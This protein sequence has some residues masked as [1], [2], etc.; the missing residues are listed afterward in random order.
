MY[1]LATYSRD[2]LNSQNGKRN[3]IHY[4]VLA[5]ESAHKKALAILESRNENQGCT[6]K[7]TSFKKS[8]LPFDSGPP[9]ALYL[10][11]IS[12]FNR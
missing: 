7:I 12:L 9:K 1:Y 3:R 10:K 6:I 8:P 4:N 2:G 11:I 5:H